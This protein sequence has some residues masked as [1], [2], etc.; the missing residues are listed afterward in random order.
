MLFIYYLYQGHKGNITSLVSSPGYLIS[1]ATDGQIKLWNATDPTR[2]CYKTTEAHGTSIS[3][4]A[5]EGSTLFSSGRDFSLCAWQLPGMELICRKEAAHS[6]EVSAMVLVGTT[7]VT[8]VSDSL[9]MWQLEAGDLVEVKVIPDLPHKVRALTYDRRREFL[10]SGAHNTIHVWQAQNRF[11]LR[12]KIESMGFSSIYS[13]ATTAQFLVVGTYNQN[14]QVLDIGTYQHYRTLT[15]HIGTVTCLLTTPHDHGQ[16]VFSG[17]QDT[18][19]Q[20]WNLENMLPVQSF[21]RHETPVTGLA[22]HNDWFFSASEEKE[23]KVF[24][25]V[26]S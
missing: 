26:K 5:V 18:T 15:G 10:Y 4:L 24:K 20:L 11:P 13:L 1:G 9:K 6:E 3:T 25:R 23:I 12:N 17:S 14:I 19:V 7:L 16:F 21:Q 8:A 2:G 22:L